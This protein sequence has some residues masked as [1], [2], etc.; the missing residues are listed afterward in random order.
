MCGCKNIFF[1]FSHYSYSFGHFFLD[2][3]NMAM[4][5]QIM[6]DNYPK[7]FCSSNPSYFLVVNK[8]INITIISGILL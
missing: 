8:N 6:L 7:K 2:K 1:Y 3:L 5:C 4:P